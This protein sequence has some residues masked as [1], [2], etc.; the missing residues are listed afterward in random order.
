MVLLEVFVEGNQVESNL[1]R[2]NVNCCSTSQSRIKVHHASIKAI[3][4]VS[5]NTILCLQVIKTLI[6]VAESNKIAVS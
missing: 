6:P 4:R 1:F 3:A 5:R 2:N